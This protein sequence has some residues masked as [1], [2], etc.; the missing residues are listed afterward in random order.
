MK[1][2]EQPVSKEYPSLMPMQASGKNC[3][4]ILGGAPMTTG[5]SL[6][7]VYEVDIEKEHW[8]RI[9]T[10][11]PI[12]QTL[13]SKPIFDL[14]KKN[15]KY[16]IYS[17][18]GMVPL[19]RINSGVRVCPPDL[20]EFDSSQNLWSRAE[21]KNSFQLDGRK[22]YGMSICNKKIFISGGM[23]QTQKVLQSIVMFD[24][25]SQTWS[26][27]NPITSRRKKAKIISKLGQNFRKLLMSKIEHI[28]T[29][30]SAYSSGIGSEDEH[31]LKQT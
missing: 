16:S 28:E 23:D 11:K 15:N 20:Y 30:N 10:N 25:E 31:T 5:Q 29:Y 13:G 6:F 4:Y 21:N 14:D 9:P 27:F 24:T 3:M 1:G 8:A 18:S 12:V 17:F 22:N 7:E 26:G 19:Q 2:S